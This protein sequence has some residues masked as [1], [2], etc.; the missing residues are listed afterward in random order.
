MS[1][2]NVHAEEDKAN[3]RD[4]NHMFTP[5]EMHTRR[6]GLCQAV[7]YWFAAIRM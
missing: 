5:T 3:N 1:T 2:L 7:V 4:Y 6:R